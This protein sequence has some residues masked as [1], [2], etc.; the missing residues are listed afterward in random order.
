MTPANLISEAKSPFFFLHIPIRSTP[1]THQPPG[2]SRGH[3]VGYH[4]GTLVPSRLR[5]HSRNIIAAIIYCRLGNISLEP[6]WWAFASFDFLVRPRFISRY[7]R[8]D[9]IHR[10]WMA[11]QLPREKHAMCCLWVRIERLLLANVRIVVSTMCEKSDLYRF[12]TRCS[13]EILFLRRSKSNTKANVEHIRSIRKHESSVNKRIIL[14]I[15]KNVIHNDSNNFLCSEYRIVLLANYHKSIAY[16]TIYI[17]PY[18]K[19][20]QITKI[21]SFEP[22]WP[23]T[24]AIGN[25][26]RKTSYI[27]KTDWRH[28]VIP[29]FD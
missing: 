11:Y 14:Y 21:V 13:K 5:F 4:H 26:G 27:R 1:P 10:S 23:I 24:N 22:N 20:R 19:F 9:A 17:A 29:S 16:T 18:W 15:W 2:S 12:R 3:E 25:S 7:A 8:P 6:P 28:I